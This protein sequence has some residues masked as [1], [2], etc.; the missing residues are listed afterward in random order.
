MARLVVLQFEDND[1]AEAFVKAQHVLWSDEHTNT[2][3]LR[4][5]EFVGLFAL[6]TIF[7]EGHGNSKQLGF[8]RGVKY[9][10]WVCSRCG[11][12]AR[13]RTIENLIRNVLSQGRNFLT[14][15]QTED[16]KFPPADV[17]T[18]N[19]PGWGVSGRG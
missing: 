4:S 17:A 1:E 11:K 7:C 13:S 16:E 12:P 10:W 19:D 14:Q 3:K 6:P 2:S 9:G 18:V 8:A 5:A 15:P